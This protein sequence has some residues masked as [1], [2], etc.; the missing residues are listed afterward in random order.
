M[1]HAILRFALL[2]INVLDSF[3][4]LKPPKARKGNAEPSPS[5]FARRKRDMKGMLCVW[6]VCACWMYLEGICD[7]TVVY[8]MPFYNEIKTMSL[9]FL[10]FTRSSGAEP[11]LMKVLRPTIRPYIKQIDSILD[12]MGMLA[13][14]AWE[15]ASLPVLAIRQRWKEFAAL[16]AEV[17]AQQEEHEK[18]ERSDVQ[19]R[20]S[21][22]ITVFSFWRDPNDRSS[23]LTD[24][25]AAPEPPAE[26]DQS[27]QDSSPSLSPSPSPPHLPPES[28]TKVESPP[29]AAAPAGPSPAERVRPIQNGANNEKQSPRRPAAPPRSNTGSTNAGGPPPFIPPM[30]IDASRYPP[31]RSRSLKS[32]Q[33]NVAPAPQPRGLNNPAI[34]KQ[35]REGMVNI[36][37][38]VHQRRRYMRYGEGD[39]A[40]NSGSPSE[41]ST[42][43]VPKEQKNT[44]MPP[45][46]APVLA[47]RTNTTDTLPKVA[48][49]L[50]LSYVPAPDPNTPEYYQARHPEKAP[51]TSHSTYQHTSYPPPNPNQNQA[52]LLRPGS[53]DTRQRGPSP[54]GF[55][56]APPAEAPRYPPSAQPAQPNAQPHD[57]TTVQA[58]PA[59]QALY[60]FPFQ[61][62]AEPNPS[63]ENLVDIDID[64]M[65]SSIGSPRGRNN[66]DGAESTHTFVPQEPLGN[67]VSTRPRPAPL[68][69]TSQ[70]PFPNVR[71]SSSEDPNTPSDTFDPP[72]PPS[73]YLGG[74]P[75]GT[76]QILGSVQTPMAPG[77]YS[78]LEQVARRLESPHDD[79]ELG[80]DDSI[81]VRDMAS[82]NPR[83]QSLLASALLGGADT[84]P[85]T[86][87]DFDLLKKQM[88]A[89][90]KAETEAF[91]GSKVTPGASRPSSNGHTAQPGQPK[92]PPRKPKTPPSA[93][94]RSPA[95]FP[96]YFPATP[97]SGKR[98]VESGVAQAQPPKV[99]P[100]VPESPTP[101]KDKGKRRAQDTNISTV[102]P[103]VNTDTRP[104]EVPVS[105]TV[106][107]VSKTKQPQPEVTQSRT[108][109]SSQPTSA[110]RTHGRR[111]SEEVARLKDVI[112][113]ALGGRTPIQ[114]MPDPSTSPIR[115]QPPTSA[116]TRTI[117]AGQAA[118]PTPAYPPK[119]EPAPAKGQPV[120]ARRSR[121][122][123]PPTSFNFGSVAP[124]AGPSGALG[125]TVTES[126][127]VPLAEAV[128]GPRP[129]TTG[130]T[131]TYGKSRTLSE[132]RPVPAGFVPD[133][134]VA[135]AAPQHHRHASTGHRGATGPILPQELESGFTASGSSEGGRIAADHGRI[136]RMGSTVS[137]KR[138]IG[139]VAPTEE[140]D[141]YGIRM[142]EIDTDSASE[143]SSASSKRR[144][145][146]PI[147]DSGRYNSTTSKTRA[148]NDLGRR[149]AAADPPK[150][151]SASSS[152]GAGN[153]AQPMRRPAE[154]S[155]RTASRDVAAT[156]EPARTTRRP[157]RPM[158]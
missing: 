7:R 72:T 139:Q 129:P 51:G 35:V 85:S 109:E 99:S 49:A 88:E 137:Q 11:I 77:G 147:P 32:T 143:A 135:Q 107:P 101:N 122:Q 90:A 55:V 154:P 21:R 93:E 6:V 132:T 36:Q 5:A 22:R 151:R 45:P 9:L 56:P 82:T 62:P 15:L 18:E 155:R 20:R 152:S 13:A 27:P 133:T 112:E 106:E 44:S 70:V 86:V 60:Y 53:H 37:A 59:N 81:S 29:A 80:P 89:E 65:F 113:K 48:P 87:Y 74:P 130:S 57:P 94:A 68:Q 40:G 69:S 124:P 79:D 104:A 138:G 3:K 156:A 134:G 33:P 148:I 98:G 117:S 8:L 84:R 140:R 103:K 26:P 128:R 38:A 46:P 30:T 119:A 145:M 28:S 123:P 116:H 102:K 157:T 66:A 54:L 144:R 142:V 146:A 61:P 58:S 91:L 78:W 17:A 4:I 24:G 67:P 14:F 12:L 83:V 100:A 136:R 95:P 141:P 63:K 126:T 1:I 42:T 47:S 96:G 50:G 19:V 39:S 16:A 114:M 153:T 120:A 131:R 25:D 125:Q 71:V 105:T 34:P 75:T 110:R 97:G 108:G 10:I 127:S 2:A 64:A 31:S 23:I 115:Q 73:N 92:T 149:I 76:R 158:S 43:R 118:A 52:P 121:P 111:Q 150:S 41:T